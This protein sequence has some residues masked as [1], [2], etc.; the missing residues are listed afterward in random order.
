MKLIKVVFLHFDFGLCSGAFFFQVLALFFQFL[1][2]LCQKNQENIAAMGNPAAR[3][4][5]RTVIVQD[6]NANSSERIW[7][8][9][10][11]RGCC[12][13]SNNH[14]VCFPAP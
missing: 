7:P 8:S 1:R 6:G 14:P 2:E 10:R 11:T 9:W 5:T 4:I 13:I 12:S 3:M